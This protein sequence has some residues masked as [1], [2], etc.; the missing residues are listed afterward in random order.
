M[1]SPP[2]QPQNPSSS[3]NII[4]RL[5][6]KY[7]DLDEQ[8]FSEKMQ[9]ALKIA[10]IFY[11][12]KQ[13][14]RT[15]FFKLKDL[16]KYTAHNINKSVYELDMMVNASDKLSYDDNKNKTIIIRKYADDDTRDIEQAERIEYKSSDIQECL[17]VTL[18]KVDVL[19][20][21]MM[22]KNNLL[23]FWD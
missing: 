10:D 19:L 8:R 2:Q 5:F 12:T 11:K 7:N 4:K 9:I 22:I 3:S 16:V 21:E 17:F 18:H 15:D 20:N 13:C 1:F 14:T 23:N 6:F